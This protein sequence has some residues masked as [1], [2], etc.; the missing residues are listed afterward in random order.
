MLTVFFY[1]KIPPSS[2]DT[3]WRCRLDDSVPIGLQLWPIRG[4]RESEG[5]RKKGGSRLS[6]CSEEGSPSVVCPVPPVVVA[7]DRHLSYFS[8]S[9]PLLPT[10]SGDEIAGHRRSAQYDSMMHN[11]ASFHFAV[12]SFWQGG[13]RLHDAKQACKYLPTSKCNRLWYMGI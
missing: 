13:P 1:K 3:V 10:C 9:F 11:T 4:Q 2:T 12:G 7:H 5:V 6:Y 8:D